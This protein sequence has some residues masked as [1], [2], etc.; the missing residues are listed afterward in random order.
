MAADKITFYDASDSSLPK[1]DTVQG[2]LDL[3][4]VPYIK[5]EI[6]VTN[7]V[8]TFTTV[9]PYDDTIPQ[10]TEGGEVVT[11]TI[12]PT[13]AS[14]LLIIDAMIT[15]ASSAAGNMSIALFQDTTANA[16]AASATYYPSGSLNSAKQL[17]LKHEMAAGTTSATTFKIRI[18]NSQAG[19]TTI[20]GDSGARKFGGVCVSMI[21]VTEVTT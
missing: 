12:T 17:N 8:A 10:N 2:I 6:G 21:K 18:G 9:M 16:L 20:N 11:V 19:T 3:I 5:S 1:T 7:A 4:S 15:Y 13:N 14:N